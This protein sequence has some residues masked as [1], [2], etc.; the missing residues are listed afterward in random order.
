MFD[1]FVYI[2]K[3]INDYNKTK[4]YIGFTNNLYR[5]IKQHNRDIKGGAK[6]TQ[7]Y[8]WKYFAIIT[9][10]RG[11]IEGLQ[12]EWRLKHS[13]KKTGI[14]NKINSFLSY[15]E[16]YNKVSPK[17]NILNK[18][19]LFYL[20]YS[21]LSKVSKTNININESPLAIFIKVK[22]ELIIIDHLMNK[23]IECN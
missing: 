20:D 16:L 15:I 22:F 9:N 10:F 3:G 1:Y 8:K 2:I 12:I 7:G 13:T 17:A 19:L 6:A 5:R 23:N 11:K 4:F 14:V 21:L 18:R